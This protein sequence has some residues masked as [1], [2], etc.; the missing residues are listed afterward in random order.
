MNDNSGITSQFGFE[1]QKLVFIYK[2][3][4][5]NNDE[6][7]IYEGEDDI[8]IDKENPLSTFETSKYLCQTKSGN[9]TLPI[10]KKILLNWLL[11]LDKHTC[12]ICVS[13]N[14]FPT[15]DESFADIFANE[16]IKSNKQENALIS[17]V[18]DK[19][20]T[21][22]NIEDLKNDIN[23]LLSKAEFLTFNIE[24]L[25]NES[26]KKFAELYCEDTCSKVIGRERYYL[27]CRTLHEDI[28]ESL[29]KKENY[30]LSFKTLFLKILSVCEAIT[31]EKY[32]ISYFEFKKRAYSKIEEI[33]E[34]QSDAVRQLKLVFP[35]NDKAVISGLTEQMFYEDLREYFISINKQEEINNL[36][37]VA[38]Y[39]YDETLQYFAGYGEERTPYKTYYKTVKKNL[40]APLPSDRSSSFSF[41]RHGC[42]IHL[43]DTGIDKDLKIK[44]GEIGDENN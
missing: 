17:R 26:I 7:I 33:L 41:Y 31:D 42:Y 28:T 38:K 11:N 15:N 25:V 23:M 24:K 35:G 37:R 19:Y 5:I 2:A 22:K 39:N 13:E 43:T 44:W 1:Y 32:D 20:T 6:Y 16:I 14:H 3:M 36:E 29:I 8:E 18:K 27:L 4:Q 34:S 40:P 9:V 30:K 10:F 21:Q 12:F